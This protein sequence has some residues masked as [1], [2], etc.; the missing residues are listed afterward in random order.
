MNDSE[1]ALLLVLVFASVRA[2]PFSSAIDLA[3]PAKLS[4][5]QTLTR[6]LTDLHTRTQHMHSMN[7]KANETIALS[8]LELCWRNEK[9]CLFTNINECLCVCSCLCSVKGRRRAEDCLCFSSAISLFFTSSF[10]KFKF[11]HL[12]FSFVVV[13]FALFSSQ[14]PCI[15]IF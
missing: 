10:S 15:T 9:F 13:A 6:T 4:H 5:T 8:Q 12:I 7:S 11:L 2:D 3:Y 14:L 1:I